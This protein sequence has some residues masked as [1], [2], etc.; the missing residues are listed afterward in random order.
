MKNLEKNIELKVLQFIF[1]KQNEEQK[2][3][4]FAT[5][6]FG[7]NSSP[8]HE[9]FLSQINAIKIISELPEASGT[10][11]CS[12]YMDDRMDSHSNNVKS[13]KQ[14]RRFFKIMKKRWYVQREI[15]TKFNDSN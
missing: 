3:L 5:F 11:L 10:A 7:V 9:Q 13:I 15:D 14:Y 2:V 4:Q 1:L 8:F 12:M 6:V